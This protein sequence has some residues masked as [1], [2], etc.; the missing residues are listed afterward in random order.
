MTARTGSAMSQKLPAVV[1][2]HRGCSFLVEKRGW[3]KA[4]RVGV[5]AWSGWVKG[6]ATG[7]GVVLGLLCLVAVSLWSKARRRG[8]PFLLGLRCWVAVALL[9][10]VL[11]SSGLAL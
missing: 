5:R 4:W 2:A 11:V 3:F 8:V 6:A 9:V 7:S 1:L 10:A